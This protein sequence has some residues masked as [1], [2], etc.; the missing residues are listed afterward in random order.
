MLQQLR[1]VDTIDLL[2]GRYSRKR[3]RLRWFAPWKTA[4]MLAGLTIALG[5]LVHGVEVLRLKHALDAQDAAN[6]ARYQQVFPNETR[7]V[8]LP[9]QLS[10]QIAALQGNSGSG[11]FMAMLDVLTQA[12]GAVPGLQVKT[13]QFRDGA[14]FAGLSATNLELLDRLKA[15][16]GGNRSA[17]F[18]VDSANSGAEGVQIRVRLA[19]A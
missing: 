9:A 16:F 3:N 1:S 19:P 15:W 5:L 13:L 2:Q 11:Q 4:A 14:L 8:D 6:I 18:S 17:Q 7:I 12:L 10:Q